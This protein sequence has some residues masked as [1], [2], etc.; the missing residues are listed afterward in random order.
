MTPPFESHSGGRGPPYLVR[1]ALD[2]VIAGSQ[3]LLKGKLNAKEL[4]LLQEAVEGIAEEHGI[5]VFWFD[6]HA[7]LFGACNGIYWLGRSH[8]WKNR[9]RSN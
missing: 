6:N 7:A 9:P 1:E 8:G 5:T 2:R 3:Q 4:L